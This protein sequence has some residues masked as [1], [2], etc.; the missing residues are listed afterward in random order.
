MTL[1]QSEPIEV[2]PS[3]KKIDANDLLKQWQRDGMIAENQAAMVQAMINIAKPLIERLAEE[4]GELRGDSDETWSPEYEDAVDIVLEMASKLDEKTLGKW[5]NKLARKMGMT[6]RDFGNALSGQRKSEK[7]KN[8]RDEKRED[9]FGGYF[10]HEGKSW[11]IEYCYN[12]LQNKGIFAFRNPDGGIEMADELTINGTRYVPTSPAD[13]LMISKRVIVF[14]THVAKESHTTR[15]IAYALEEFIKTQCLIDDPKMPKVAAYFIMQ[16]WLYDRFNSIAYLRAI[17]D[18]GSGKSEIMR[19]I[20]HLCYRLT[21][22][23]GADSLSTFFR[24]TTTYGGTVFFEEADLPEGSGSDNPIV[25]FINLGAMRGNPILRSEEYTH[26][27][28]SKRYRSMPFE[29]YCPKIF[30][31][32]EDYEDDAVASRSLTMKLMG[33][34]MQE[35][36]DANIPLEMNSSYWKQWDEITSMLLRW[37]LEKWQPEIREMDTR[38]MDPMVSPRMNQVTAAVKALAAEDNDQIFLDQVRDVLRGLYQDEITKRSNL[39]EAR[40]VEGLWKMYIY[41]DLQKRLEIRSDGRI[42]IKIGDIT[43][44]ANNIV[45]EMNAEGA[46]LRNTKDDGTDTKKKKGYE[47]SSHRVGKFVRETLLLETPPRTG[48]GYYCIWDDVKL[49]IAGQK[50]GVLPELEKIKAAREA[51][52]SMN[53]RVDTREP[54]QMALETDDDE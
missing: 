25:K 50:Y 54:L 49:E 6:T 13:D 26:E 38:L 30:A 23:S 20:G 29:T 33:K 48:K 35:L 41:P 15:T 47:V 46:D 19:R 52:A 45:E 7:T 12:P 4:A 53:A 22:A 2:V 10:V 24:T 39:I 27:D 37:R 9:I 51:L 16:T 42:A 17:G 11:F 32:R 3:V 43:A 18:K 34:Q 40:I 44:I 21:K 28:G 36:L 31:Q 1:P 5:K 8:K 14:P